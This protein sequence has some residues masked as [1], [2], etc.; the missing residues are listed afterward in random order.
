[1]IDVLQNSVSIIPCP[2]V[3]YTRIC[4]SL[5]CNCRT[6]TKACVTLLI[7][8]AADP[9]ETVSGVCVA[10][11]AVNRKDNIRSADCK[12]FEDSAKTWGAES[13]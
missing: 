7:A 6:W 3:V 8:S 2:S 4:S 10:D 1:M 11:R 13:A 12:A 5:R 9:I